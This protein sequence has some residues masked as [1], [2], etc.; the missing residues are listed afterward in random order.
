[1][2]DTDLT[3]KSTVNPIQKLYRVPGGGSYMILKIQD[4][5]AYMADC[6]L[7]PPEIKA[8]FVIFR[9][10]VHDLESMQPAI[11]TFGHDVVEEEWEYLSKHTHWKRIDGTERLVPNQEGGA[12][13]VIRIES[14]LSRLLSNFGE[15][16]GIDPT[17][18]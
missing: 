13:K 11:H 3:E 17:K 4:G 18:L 15:A 6:Y 2:S 5:Y 1:M 12:S 10:M 8:F 9:E 16:H 7:N 14:E